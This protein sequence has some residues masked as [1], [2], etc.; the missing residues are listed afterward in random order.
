MHPLC[1]YI[2]Y[3]T[4]FDFVINFGPLF[5]WGYT[6]LYFGS[7]YGHLEVVQLLLTMSAE[8]DMQAKV[9]SKLLFFSCKMSLTKPGLSLIASKVTYTEWCSV[10]G[11]CQKIGWGDPGIV[12]VK[13]S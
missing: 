1:Y 10:L 8:V 6:A 4:P 12:T 5:Q 13:H 2:K 3:Y 9:S 7:Y 11:H